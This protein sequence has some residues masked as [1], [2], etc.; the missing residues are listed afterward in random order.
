MMEEKVMGVEM[1]V[2]ME[3]VVVTMVTMEVMMVDNMVVANL[4]LDGRGGG[5]DEVVIM[6]KSMRM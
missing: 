1:M 2:V 4:S 3:V 6:G 5:D